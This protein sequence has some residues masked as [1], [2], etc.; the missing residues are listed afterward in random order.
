MSFTPVAN[1]LPVSWTPVANFPPGKKFVE[2]IATGFV[3]TGGN[4][5][6]GVNDTGGAP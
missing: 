2:K 5:D 4:F 1:L 6:T 3:D